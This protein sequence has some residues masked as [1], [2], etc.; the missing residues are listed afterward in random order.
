MKHRFFDMC[1]SVLYAAAEAVLRN[2]RFSS[3]SC[4]NCLV[5]GFL[6]ACTFKSGDLHN[7]A[8]KLL[9]KLFSIYFVA[10]FADNVHHIYRNDNRDAKFYKLSCKIK[11]SFKVCSVDNVKNSLRALAYKI[12]SCDYLF[13]RIRRKRVNTRKVGYYYLL[14]PFKL[15]FFFF[16]RYAGPVSDKLI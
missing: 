2:S 10:V 15:S 1:K 13:K 3:F 6:Y 12:I 16:Y 14:I 5:S 9:C 8:A 7:I 4:L 11:V